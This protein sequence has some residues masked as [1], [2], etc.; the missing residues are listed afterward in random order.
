MACSTF[1]LSELTQGAHTLGVVYEP[2]RSVG[3]ILERVNRRSA[4]L[5]PDPEGGAGHSIAT[6][7][8][9]IGAGDPIPR[10]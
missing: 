9:A 8:L 1:L 10:H 7:M 2:V 3:Q 4:V 6:Y 5:H